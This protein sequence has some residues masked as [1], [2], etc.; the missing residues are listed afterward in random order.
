MEISYS[1]PDNTI[2]AFNVNTVDDDYIKT[3]GMEIVNGRDFLPDNE[4]DKRRSIIVNEAFVKEFNLADPIGKRIPN[5]GFS[6]HEII[7]V[8][9]D[10]NFAS[11]HSKVK[12]LVMS[13]NI[14]LLLSGAHGINIE[15]PFAPKLVVRLK[16]GVVGNGLEAIREKWESIYS[17]DPFNYSFMDDAINKQYLR[18][19]NLG[20]IVTTATILSVIIGAL[21]LFGLAT[22]TMTARMKEIS[23][24]KVLGANFGSLLITL[25]RSYII[26]TL[27][28][29][30]IAV[31]FTL[32]F[33]MNWLKA[34]EFKIEVTP[35]T[36]LLGGCIMLLVSSL[37]IAYQSLRIVKTDPAQSL[38]S[39]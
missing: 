13:Q 11:L 38:R 18:D 25:T 15:S 33:I 35:L 1:D 5:T 39:E 23:I 16:A 3:M 34:F 14:D 27:A 19:G 17:G 36:F 30:L 7:G 24:R 32:Y 29:V 21:G 28:S 12:P 6:D 10:F 31:P 22:L 8:V 2:H 9:K 26:L 37:A 4:S 20:K